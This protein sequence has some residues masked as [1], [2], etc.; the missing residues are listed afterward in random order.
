MSSESP[1]SELYGSNGVEIAIQNNTALPTGVGGIIAVGSD[2]T[3]A[4]FI[5]VDTSGDQIVVGLGTAG[6]PA[7]GVV[8]VQGV[9]GMTALTV[10]NATAANLLANV[11]GL[12]A[13]GSASSG[14]P[15]WVAG[16]V[17][18]SA[19]SYADST[20]NALSLTTTGLLRIDGSGVTQPVSGTVTADQGTANT[21]ANA[22]PMEITDGYNGPAAVK[23][24]STPAVATDS[25]LVVALSPNSNLPVEGTNSLG[26]VVSVSATLTNGLTHLNVVD[27]QAVNKLDDLLL[28]LDDI[29]QAIT[30]GNISAKIILPASTIQPLYANLNN[31]AI[32]LPSLGSAAARSSASI[33]NSSNLFEDVLMMFQITT[34]T[35]GVSATGYVN[36]YG[37]GAVDG[38][39]IFPEGITG[40]DAVVTLT[41]PPN[42]VL[43]AQF[44]A[45]TTSATKTFGPISF[46]RMYGLD[47][48]PQTWGVV[49]SNQTGAAFG[50]GPAGFAITY[51]G[52][53]GQLV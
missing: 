33:D 27:D 53:N 6:T 52:I 38:G 2:G 23:P 4:R 50:I 40:T 46:C 11:G 14:N 44:N 48:L 16:N 28:S 31:I 29:G 22:W 24:P 17:T 18:I 13:A 9:T 45:N 30:S 37:Y 49:V 51:Q 12:G 15:V 10:N 3:T 5:K 8:S 47:K 26:S 32:T 35:T 25:A 41:A 39:I 43:I 36:V 34:A 7:G 21:L 42:L 1:A 19:P 20:V